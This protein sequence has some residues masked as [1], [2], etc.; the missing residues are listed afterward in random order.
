[1]KYKKVKIMNQNLSNKE[2]N[3]IEKNE[4]DIILP[5]SKNDPL[6]YLIGSQNFASFQEE[7]KVINI[8]CL[9]S[10]NFNFYS[11]Q[12]LQDT[13]KDYEIKKGNYTFIYN[14][15]QNTKANSE[16]TFIA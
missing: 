15:C 16:S 7:A 8:K 12:S 6:P 10:K 9:F 1:M 4:S 5:K 11:L 3:Q 13:E 14:F 2:N